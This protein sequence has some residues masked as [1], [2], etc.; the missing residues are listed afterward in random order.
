MAPYHTGTRARLGHN[1]WRVKIMILWKSPW[2]WLSEMLNKQSFHGTKLAWDVGTAIK[3]KNQSNYA[4]YF[5]PRLLFSPLSSHRWNRAGQ[6]FFL[7]KSALLSGLSRC[8]HRPA[9]TGLPALQENAEVGL[10]F[11]NI[12]LLLFT[13]HSASKNKTSIRVFK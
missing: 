8:W 2:S 13:T 12:K 1:K 7:F 5:L 4:L 6:F 10:F 11:L 3:K 9:E